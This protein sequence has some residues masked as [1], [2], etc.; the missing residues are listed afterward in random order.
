MSVDGIN[1]SDNDQ[2]VN[3]GAEFSMFNN[4]FVLRGGY[5]ELFLK[6]HERGLTMGAGFNTNIQDYFDLRIAYAYQSLE[7][8]NSV[9]RF[10]LIM[11]F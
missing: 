3:T 7:H 11:L 2:S 5:S 10:T 4:M 6:D 9:S 8:L 1:P